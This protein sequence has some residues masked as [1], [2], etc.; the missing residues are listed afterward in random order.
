MRKWAG[1]R[2]LGVVCGLMTITLVGCS[3]T[4]PS[5]DSQ[6]GGKT[7]IT[8]LEDLPQ[9]TYPVEG[10]VMNLFESEARIRDLA[11]KV[12]AD[13]EQDLAA[14][15]V[16][17][18]S[19]LQSWE[20]ALLTADLL[21]GR[22]AEARKR[23]ERIRQLEDKEAARL[24]AGL[25]TLSML[26]AKEKA[27]PASDFAAYAAAYQQELTSRLERLP[28]N[29]V[30]DEIEQTKGRTEI[31]SAN[32]LKGAVAA[33]L[34]PRVART[35]VLSFDQAAGVI[36]TYH[37]L[38]HRLPLKDA[39]LAALDRY[40]SANAR[41]KEDIWP[42]RAVALDPD[43]DRAPVMVAVWDS[44]V[45]V[46]LFP[47]QVYNNRSEIANFTD[48]DGN[49]FIDDIHGVAYDYHAKRDIGH[50]APID[51]V[52]DRIDGLIDLLKGLSDIQAN[53]ASPEASALKRQLSE[54]QQSSVPA[55]LQDLSLVGNYAHGTHVAG[56]V[57]EGNPSAAL[58]VARHTYDHHL[59]PVARTLE[60]GKLDA[61]KCRDTV[62][63]LQ[64]R[65]VRVVNMSWGESRQDAED[66]LD[67]NG[68]GSTPED[69]RALARRVFELQKE[70]LYEA[71]K[72]APEILFVC[73][74]GNA[75][76]DVAFDEFIPSSFDLPNLIVVGA[77]D[78]AGE[79]TGFTSFG[80]TV[81]VYA[82]GFEVESVVPGGR[83][84]KMS[85][86]SMASPAV[87]NLAAKLIA[88]DPS[89]TPAKVIAL[90]RKGCDQRTF[91]KKKYL[92][93]NP[94]RTVELLKAPKRR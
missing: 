14:Y 38:H 54:M 17:D 93:L 53:V 23:V 6:R 91:G 31:M 2:G 15:H 89:L 43:P 45:D 13:V 28:W 65:G 33:Q 49:G 70:A 58:L 16:E 3:G 73:A 67:A 37:A 86:T 41:P 88:L 52:A 57:M 24:T 81:Q 90:I 26:A 20:G 4:G 51:E 47:G 78:Q 55:F 79:P 10:T 35:G 87:A 30:Q 48:D 76:N 56:I 66:S 71:I 9:H 75:D 59:V 36:S 46:S 40:I 72:N 94:R 83:R 68:I 92:L 34:E 39:T 84:I 85:G 27:D 44:G 19:T 69:R 32:L 18:K 82:N 5:G 29:V 25:A 60:W 1:R 77:V 74:A 50:L 7:P 62:A 12:R 80:P 64:E 61:A 42:Q 21:E 22:D 11:A 63:Y 8:R